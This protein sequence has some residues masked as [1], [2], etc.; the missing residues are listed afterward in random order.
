[1]SQVL[2]SKR[3]MLHQL[4]TKKASEFE[5]MR[6]GGREK[7]W[8][9]NCFC[10]INLSLPVPLIRRKKLVSLGHY[11]FGK[12]RLTA[13]GPVMTISAGLMS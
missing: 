3:V 1:M 9:Q 11:L 5:W 6:A 2:F 4:H 10:C 8:F 12:R 13:I 7:P